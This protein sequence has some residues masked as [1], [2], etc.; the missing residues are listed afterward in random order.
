VWP[1]RRTR[2]KLAG[3]PGEEETGHT[4]AF[5]FFFRFHFKLSLHSGPPEFSPQ[6]MI[7]WEMALDSAHRVVSKILGHLPFEMFSLVFYSGQLCL[8]CR[9]VQFPH[10][11]RLPAHGVPG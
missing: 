7:G 10:L 4:V 6:K 8:F 1:N 2:Y 11:F 3:E 5:F 9:S